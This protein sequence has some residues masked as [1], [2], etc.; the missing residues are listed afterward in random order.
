MLWLWLHPVSHSGQSGH[1]SFRPGAPQPWRV[2]LCTSVT[3]SCRH[4]E[5]SRGPLEESRAV[6]R[7]VQDVPLGILA[8]RG[9]A[10]PHPLYFCGCARRW[11]YS[12]P[13]QQPAFQ[14]VAPSALLSLALSF[15]IHTR[16]RHTPSRSHN[17]TVSAMRFIPHQH[18]HWLYVWIPLA[19]SFMWFGAF[20]IYSTCT[21]SAC[22]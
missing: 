18:Q 5:G 12:P 7:C 15:L 21:L 19:G 2:L 14:A 8:G 20:I 10:Y 6:G 16:S 13:S 9:L 11:P 3:S 22:P 4:S 17:R 1:S